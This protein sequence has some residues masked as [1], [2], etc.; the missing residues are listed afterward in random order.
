MQHD[1][2]CDSKRQPSKSQSEHQQNK[3]KFSLGCIL[4]KTLGH[5]FVKRHPHENQKLHASAHGA[6]WDDEQQVQDLRSPE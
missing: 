4:G 3:H 5:H 1:A 2:P 6:G